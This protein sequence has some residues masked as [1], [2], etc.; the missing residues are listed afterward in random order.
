MWFDQGSTYFQIGHAQL[1]HFTL[2]SALKSL[3]ANSVQVSELLV[4]IER[5][6]GFLRLPY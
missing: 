3:L 5:R 6:T 2:I 4:A 1:I